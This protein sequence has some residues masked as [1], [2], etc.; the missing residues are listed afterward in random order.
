MIS[1][2]RETS[3]FQ[4]PLATLQ[5]LLEFGNFEHGK[6]RRVEP[7][8]AFAAPVRLRP[9]DASRRIVRGY[10]RELSRSGIGLL[11]ESPLTIG[12]L[13]CLTIDHIGGPLLLE[14]EIMWCRE[15]GDGWYLAGC[16][17]INETGPGSGD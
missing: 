8:F 7:R 14:A 1:S 2:H 15:A 3:A 10:A 17:F 12:E 5:G 4:L 13:Y 11:C 16:R 6:E 9:R